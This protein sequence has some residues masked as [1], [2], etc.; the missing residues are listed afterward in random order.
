MDTMRSGISTKGQV[1]SIGNSID[2]SNFKEIGTK[3]Y[4]I[5][6]SIDIWNFLIVLLVLKLEVNFTSFKLI[7]LRLYNNSLLTKFLRRFE[8]EILELG[9]FINRVYE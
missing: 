3:N 8:I 2:L 6:N 4:W 1:I 9:L 7:L 5:N